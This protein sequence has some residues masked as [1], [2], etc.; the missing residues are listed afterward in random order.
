[1]IVTGSR[2]PCDLVDPADA[3]AVASSLMQAPADAEAVASSLVQ[4]PA[5]AEAVA[6][7]LVQAPADA[8]ASSLMQDPANAEAVAS[9]L[10]QDPAAPVVIRAAGSAFDVEA[11]EREVRI[12]H[13]FRFCD[14]LVYYYVSDTAKC[15]CNFVCVMFPW[16]AIV[17]AFT[18]VF[19]LAAFD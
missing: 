18:K 7:S 9:S 10:T 1:M 2:Y 6:S 8:V 3:E 17:D 5:D 19:T 13:V 15:I 12:T 11:D 16:L 14:A 4:D